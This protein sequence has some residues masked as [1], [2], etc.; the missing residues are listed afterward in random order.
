MSRRQIIEAIATGI[1]KT[2]DEL[3]EAGIKGYADIT[4]Q[5]AQ[6]F[7]KNT[8][9]ALIAAGDDVVTDANFSRNLTDI[10]TKRIQTLKG[11]GADIPDGAERQLALDYTEALQHQV[12]T[13]LKQTAEAVAEN[14]T[15]TVAAAS[16]TLDE[17]AESVAKQTFQS[18]KEIVDYLRKAAKNPERDIN[19]ADNMD[20][21]TKML[22]QAGRLSDDAPVAKTPKAIMENITNGIDEAGNPVAISQN[23]LN[24]LEKYFQTVNRAPA[25]VNNAGGNMF[26][27]LISN[28]RSAVSNTVSAPF[29]VT[30]DALYE[31]SGLTT[32]T[33][34]GVLASIV[35]VGAIDLTLKD[36]DFDGNVL[37]ENIAPI[38]YINHSAYNSLSSIWGN[39]HN[40]NM[41]LALE[42]DELVA[43]GD[44]DYAQ[45]VQEK[46][47]RADKGNTDYQTAQRENQQKRDAIDADEAR[48]E[49]DTTRK[50][51]YTVD[52]ITNSFNEHVLGSQQNSLLT[53]Q[54][55]S[56]VQGYADDNGY[57][58]RMDQEEWS[59]MFKGTDFADMYNTLSE[60]MRAK[61]DQ[62]AAHHYKHEMI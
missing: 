25:A 16:R 56:I 58:G 13:T 48:Y 46:K 47:Q 51:G 26:S 37:T 33:S 32:A 2:S 23:Q 50:F 62:V 29:R 10:V 31:S 4:S 42:N 57:A 39:D 18:P 28:V 60:D 19:L 38:A 21:L 40:E 22:S 8:T 59:A 14:V 41:V 15:E 11:M 6:T 1:A 52:Q 45:L 5:T 34:A 44:I 12:E 61:L 30:R 53:N 20:Q 9:K 17:A 55:K 24:D 54:F 27:N 7:L 35:T 49:Q 36:V 43:T 3:G